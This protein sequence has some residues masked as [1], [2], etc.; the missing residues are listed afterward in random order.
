MPLQVQ[1][2]QPHLMGVSGIAC[3]LREQSKVAR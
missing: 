1:L 3:N 2:R